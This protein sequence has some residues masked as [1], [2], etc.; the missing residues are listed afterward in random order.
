MRQTLE[1][2][3]EQPYRYTVEPDPGFGY[4]VSFPDLPGCMTQV[5]DP[6]TIPAMADEIRALWLESAWHNEAEIPLPPSTSDYSGKFVVRLPR[7]LHRRLAEA[8][9]REGVSL[10]QHVVAL[11]AAGEA[12]GRIATL[13]AGLAAKLDAAGP[14]ANG[15]SAADAT[16]P[17]PD[18]G[19]LV[20]ASTERSSAA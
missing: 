5:S 17:A 16:D 6:A 11:L 4:F 8:A 20:A 9:T 15:T 7:S 13:V 12:Q 19:R 3:L 2:Y 14:H 18:A 1:F 10:N